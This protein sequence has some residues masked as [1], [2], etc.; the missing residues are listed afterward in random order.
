MACLKNR[1]QTVNIG[2]IGHV[3]ADDTCKAFRGIRGILDRKILEILD[4]T[5]CWKC[6]ELLIL[7]SPGYIVLF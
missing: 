4:P 6:I 2:M 1:D 3:S 5:N 7:P